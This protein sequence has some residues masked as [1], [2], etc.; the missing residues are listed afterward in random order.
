M[1]GNRLKDISI[2]ELDQARERVE[3]TYRAAGGT[4][5]VDRDKRKVS[6]L[7]TNVWIIPRERP[8][9]HGDEATKTLDLPERIED[10]PRLT[11]LT[12]QQ[13]QRK[14]AELERL[15]ASATPV[16]VIMH[17]QVAFSFAC[18]GF[19]LVGIP[20]GLRSH[21]R[22]TS[23]GVAIGLGLVLVYYS[24]IFLGQSLQ[25]KPQFAPHLIVWMPNFLFQV[26]GGVLLW[27]A[28]KGV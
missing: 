17:S 20:L 5:N 18:I 6:L 13:L 23:V 4:I 21:R 14:R 28:N 27:R 15:G 12:F 8:G 22:E 2:Y 25:A 24:F 9:M 10:E 16:E 26:V 19:T 1:D 3:T 7:L 11:D